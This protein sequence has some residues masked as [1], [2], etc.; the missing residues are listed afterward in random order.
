MYNN[1]QE[2]QSGLW[3]FT[4]MKDV[5][6]EPNTFYIEA[7]GDDATYPCSRFLAVD[8]VTSCTSTAPAANSVKL[9]LAEKN[10]LPT[11]SASAQWIVAGTG[12]S[13]ITLQSK[14]AKQRILQMEKSVS[15][16]SAATIPSYLAVL[17]GGTRVMLSVSPYVFIPLKK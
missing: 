17:D 13:G 8:K 12:A 3:K 11:P 6:S 1:K 10:G 15:K 7:I 14:C 16:E 4:A 2:I 9:R 5:A